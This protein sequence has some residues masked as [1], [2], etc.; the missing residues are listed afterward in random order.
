MTDLDELYPEV[1]QISQLSVRMSPVRKKSITF[2]K[3]CHEV[4]SERNIDENS[5]DIY[6]D[7]SLD[8]V[9]QQEKNSS[10]LKLTD[11]NLDIKSDQ[12]LSK[13][14]LEN[15]RLITE[16]KKLEAL[17]IQLTKNISSL[18]VTAKKELQKKEKE[19]IELRKIVDMKQG[20]NSDKICQHFKDT[21][22][23]FRNEDKTSER[24]SKIKVALDKSRYYQSLKYEESSKNKQENSFFP[25]THND[26]LIHSNPLT[27]SPI[28]DCV[29]LFSRP[30]VEDRLSKINE[31][32]D[33]QE[34]KLFKNMGKEQKER[35]FSNEKEDSNFTHSS[36]KKLDERT[37]TV[38]V[39]NTHHVSQKSIPQDT[40]HFGKQTAK[41]Q[42]NIDKLEYINVVRQQSKPNNKLT[43]V[44]EKNTNVK[45]HSDMLN[46]PFNLEAQT[47]S[48]VS[49]HRKARDSPQQA[50]SQTC[51]LSKTKNKQ[52]I[53]RKISLSKDNPQPGINNKHP[54][55]QEISQPADDQTLS[56][57]RENP[58]A[59]SQDR[60]QEFISHTP[61]F[62]SSK[63]TVVSHPSYSDLKECTK[64]LDDS[65]K[66]IESDI[67]EDHFIF[68]SYTQSK[69][70]L[71]SDFKKFKK[72]SAFDFQGQLSPDSTKVTSSKITIKSNSPK[73]IRSVTKNLELPEIKKNAKR[74]NLTL[75]KINPCEEYS[76][77]TP[78]KK[79]K[80]VENNEMTKNVLNE[81]MS[82]DIPVS[83][84]IN[85]GT[86][87]SNSSFTNQ[88]WPFQMNTNEISKNPYDAP[89]ENSIFGHSSLCMRTFPTDNVFLTSNT[90]QKSTSSF[91]NI[92]S[93]GDKNDTS[94]RS[95]NTQNLTKSF[96]AQQEQIESDIRI[97]PVQSIKINNKVLRQKTKN[98]FRRHPENY[99]SESLPHLSF[100][101]VLTKKSKDKSDDSIDS[102]K[103]GSNSSVSI[104]SDKLSLSGEDLSKN[105]KMSKLESPVPF[106]TSVTCTSNLILLGDEETTCTTFVSPCKPHYLPSEFYPPGVRATVQDEGSHARHIRGQ[107]EVIHE[108]LALS[109]LLP[110][111]NDKNNYCHFLQKEQEIK[112]DK[113]GADL[114]KGVIKKTNGTMASKKIKAELKPKSDGTLENMIGNSLNSWT[115]LVEHK[116]HKV[117]HKELRTYKEGNLKISQ[118]IKKLSKSRHNQILEKKIELV[119]RSNQ[120]FF[121]NGELQNV[122]V[123]PTIAKLIGEHSVLTKSFVS[124]SV[125][126]TNEMHTK[127]FEDVLGDIVLEEVGNSKVVSHEKCPEIE[128]NANSCDIHLY[129]SDEDNEVVKAKGKISN[130]CASSSKITFSPLRSKLNKKFSPKKMDNDILPLRHSS[131]VKFLNATFIVPKLNTEDELTENDG[132]MLSIPN[133]NVTQH[134]DIPVYSEEI[135]L[136][137][138]SLSEFD[139]DV[140]NTPETHFKNV[141]IDPSSS[142]L[143]FKNKINPMNGT[144]NYTPSQFAHSPFRLPVPYN[145]RNAFRRS[146]ETNDKENPFKTLSPELSIPV[147]DLPDSI[148]SR[149]KSFNELKDSKLV[150]NQYVFMDP[151]S[152][153]DTNKINVRQIEKKNESIR[154]VENV[155]KKLDLDCNATFSSCMKSPLINIS[156]S[157]TSPPADIPVLNYSEHAF[158]LK[159]Q[160]IQVSESCETNSFVVN[161]ALHQP[162][163]EEVVEDG[164]ILDDSCENKLKKHLPVPVSSLRIDSRKRDVHNHSKHEI[165]KEKSET[166]KNASG[167][168]ATVLLEKSPETSRSGYRDSFVKFG[169]RSWSHEPTKNA[170]Y[171]VN[172]SDQ[173]L[174]SEK[175]AKQHKEHNSDK[176]MK[177]ENGR[178]CKERDND[179]R[180]WTR[181]SI[182]ESHRQRQYSNERKKYSDRDRDRNHPSYRY[183]TFYNDKR[184]KKY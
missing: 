111:S 73:E 107:P 21:S 121:Q 126:K 152:S 20:S 182:R 11:N 94:Q 49:F 147:A 7:L 178:H 18:Y 54:S 168:K 132:H 119:N 135:S 139:V 58:Q 160:L 105:T 88:T 10:P 127:S 141:P 5:V 115:S 56:L 174:N 176:K 180:N 1:F 68:Q 158:F 72:S 181:A 125:N 155:R 175:N 24:N 170:N 167:K 34:K 80:F 45:K 122:S 161:L 133:Q 86:E 26:K 81:T 153:Y 33:L 28:K 104:D 22:V 89:S 41:V 36:Q 59:L 17:K 173:S 9:Y 79:Y 43:S 128:H 146:P 27:E 179:K 38:P 184:T 66:I 156:D 97:I 169:K 65:N 71:S 116:F 76:N 87:I 60:P 114:C 61:C 157:L 138:A 44:L 102:E 8:C 39:E 40:K 151:D 42:T 47:N 164:E 15:E 172:D 90:E 84:K 35:K 52:N 134:F 92:D 166:L 162:I 75:S 67:Q 101:K 154:K 29:Q 129:L 149:H 108:P 3:S 46:E 78:V 95:N 55:T 50:I 82:H 118:S 70:Q 113:K 112:S 30:S 123:L 99:E 100:S 91:I 63:K 142:P 37:K 53:N 120:Q 148:N 51:S 103:A 140:K 13:L 4:T 14:R 48:D 62:A 98:V 165:F 131:G 144:D 32:C 85:F 137:D 83:Y 69:D 93:L 2:F 159:G 163:S 150:K 25:A 77:L 19:L 130:S 6:S 124:E 57:S 12:E 145:K 117:F 109:L 106:A 23:E 96:C 31:S 177:Y 136:V 143:S 183:R 16:N 110:Y 171:Q 74:K 64:S